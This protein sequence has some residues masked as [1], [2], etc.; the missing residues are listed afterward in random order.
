[1]W[2]SNG[3]LLFSGLFLLFGIPLFL[4][5]LLLLRLCNIRFLVL[6][7]RI[8]LLIYSLCLIGVAGLHLRLLFFDFFL[9][10]FLRLHFIGFRLL[11]FAIGAHFLLLPLLCLVLLSL[12]FRLFM[13]LFF[14]FR[15]NLHFCALLSWVLIYFFRFLLRVRF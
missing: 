3:I 11:L 8:Y 12:H 1:M 13:G 15:L 14:W 4:D 6:F 9:F 10:F 7:L 5:W 2:L